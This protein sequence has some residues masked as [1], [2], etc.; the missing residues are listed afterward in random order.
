[1]NIAVPTG[2]VLLE[3][4]RPA[5]LDALGPALKVA[6]P[7]PNLTNAAMRL[8]VRKEWLDFG[9]HALSFSNFQ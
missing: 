4:A 1:M 9:V 6:N 2:H 7:S 5:L 3:H 8:A